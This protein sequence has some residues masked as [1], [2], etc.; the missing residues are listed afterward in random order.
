MLESLEGK[1]GL[2]RFKPPLP[3][4]EG[5]FGKP[6]VVNNVLTLAA[7]TTVLAKGAYYYQQYGTGRSRGTLTVQLA[8]NIRQGGLVEVA[9]GASLRELVEDIG[10]GTATGRPI[11]AIQVGGPLGAYLP[12]SQWDT[13]LDYETFTAAGAML[14]HGGI[15]VFDDSVDM[16]EQA[17]FAME[18]CAVE[19]CGKCTPC[20]IGSV[21][22][23]EL[24]DSIRHGDQA[25]DQIAARLELLEELCETMD[26]GSLCAMGGLTPMPVRSAVKHFPQDFQGIPNTDR[27]ER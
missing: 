8:G 10:G 16:L 6:T 12:E 15:V 5:L 1:R 26:A 2:V 20:R 9:F 18:F 17:R 27:V 14:G 24:I 4:I 11:R 19:S 13:A 23:A 21:R 7:V 3:A 25:R 22:G